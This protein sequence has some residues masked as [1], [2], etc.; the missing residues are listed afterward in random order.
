MDQFSNLFPARARPSSRAAFLFQYDGEP[1]WRSVFEKTLEGVEDLLSKQSAGGEGPY[2]CGS[3]LSAADIFYLPF[4]ERYRYQLTCLHPVLEP[5]DAN[6]YPNLYRWY[7]AMDQIPE[8]ACRVRGDAQSWAKVLAMHGYGNA[9][10]PVEVTDRLHL[11]RTRPE[12]LVNVDLNV[13]RAYAESRQD[14]AQSSPYEHAA[15]ILVRNRRALSVD[16]LKRIANVTP[17]EVDRSLRGLAQYLIALG[18]DSSFSSA[19]NE[20][21]HKEA[22]GRDVLRMAQFLSDRMCVPRDMGSM[23]ASCVREIAMSASADDCDVTV[24]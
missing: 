21:S 18:S 16:A 12:S 20:T 7:Q 10:A 3:H 17:D 1:L 13:W 14:V 2:L 11:L 15:L 8:Y 6:V 9:G 19:P 5:C 24:R 4:L 23:P 22:V